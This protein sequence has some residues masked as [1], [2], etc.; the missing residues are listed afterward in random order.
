[1]PRQFRDTKA[2]EIDIKRLI[3]SSKVTWIN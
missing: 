3:W 1:M 2:Y